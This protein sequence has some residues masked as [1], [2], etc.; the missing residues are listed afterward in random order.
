ML[1]FE[2]DAQANFLRWVYSGALEVVDLSLDDLGR[3]I[4]IMEK[5]ADLPADFADATLV[6]IADR[7]QIREV[8]TLDRDFQVYRYR[9][10]YTFKTPLLNAR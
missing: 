2:R 4:E 5:H 3:S 8:L 10:R 9:R 7:M 1:R 6:A